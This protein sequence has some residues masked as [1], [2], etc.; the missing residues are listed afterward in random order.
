MSSPAR[1][2]DG[3]GGTGAVV[4][5]P[6]V[7]DGE[8]LDDVDPRDFTVLTVPGIIEADGDAR[9][10]LMLDGQ[11]GPRLVVAAVV[12]DE[13][14]ARRGYMAI[15]TDLSEQRRSQ[16]EISKLATTD[17]LTGLPNRALFL[18]R[19]QQA[20]SRAEREQQSFAL[21]FADLD[22]F[23]AVNDVQL[24]LHFHT[25]PNVPPDTIAKHPGRVGRSVFFTIVSGFQMNLVNILAAVIAANVLERYPNIRIAFGESGW[26]FTA[27]I[28]ESYE[29]ARARGGAARIEPIPARSIDGR[30][31]FI[32]KKTP[33]WLMLHTFR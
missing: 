10:L 12:R 25:F 23:K 2:A 16:D 14:G 28:G 19:L 6:V 17:S 20:V 13:T 4:E 30:T 18:D 31:A 9:V 32:P 22:H 8:D 33:S 24:P 27:P 21:L 11:G 26:A 7:Y 3:P 1:V 15:L 5:I 29:A